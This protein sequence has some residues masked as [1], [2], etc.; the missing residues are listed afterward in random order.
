MPHRARAGV[1]AAMLAVLVGA[2]SPQPDTAET[3]G[4][5]VSPTTR[6]AAQGPRPPGPLFSYL[7]QVGA[8]GE[9]DRVEREKRVEEL[10]AACMADE[11]FE[12][13]PRGPAPE[14][15]EWEQFT[16]E[17][18]QQYGYGSTTTV[19]PPDTTEPAD[20]NEEYLESLSSSARTAY[21]QAMWDFSD[22]ENP[23]GCAGDAQTTVYQDGRWEEDPAF[24]ELHAQYETWLFAMLEDPR[25]TEAATEWSACMADAGYDVATP[26]DAQESLSG[27]SS[28]VIITPEVQ[29][30]EIDTAVADLTCQIETDY[31]TSMLAAQHV[32][33]Q[34]FVDAHR[35]ELEALVEAYA[36]DAG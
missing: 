35:E 27:G 22:P 28:G 3:A 33:E 11:G 5:S 18:A 1:L 9:A 17:Y 6:T 23:G 12:Y 8:D 10:V 20:P 30:R 13:W 15:D 34:E 2:C 32:M 25:M 16:L 19:P 36:L 31:Q 26:S 29:K 4:P 24:A 7:Q 21:D 14:W